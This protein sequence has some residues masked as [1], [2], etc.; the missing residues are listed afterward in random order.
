MADL[1][2]RNIPEETKKRLA[3]RAAENGRSQSAEVVAML[4]KELQLQ[5]KSWVIQLYEAFQEVGGVELELP[6]RHQAREFSF[7]DAQ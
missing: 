7:G 4:N 6:E 5:G 3:V 1:L 2:V